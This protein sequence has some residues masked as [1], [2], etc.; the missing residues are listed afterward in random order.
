MLWLVPAAARDS[1]LKLLPAIASQ[2]QPRAAQ[3]NLT[4]STYVAILVWNQVQAP[5]PIAPEPASP[6]LARVNVKCYMRRGVA[7]LLARIA[8]ESRLSANAAAEALIARDLRAAEARLTIF[9]ARG[10]TKPRV[11]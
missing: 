4:I 1:S 11:Q 6:Q 8:K 2:V 3:L 9:P 10:T 5:A 7:P